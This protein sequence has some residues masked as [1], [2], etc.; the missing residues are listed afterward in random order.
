MSDQP[1][2]ALLPD[3]LRDSLPPEAGHEAAVLH[4]LMAAFTA[5]GYERVDPPL[6]EFE[7]S[8]L[9]GAG[10]GLNRHTFRLMDPVSQRMMGLRADMT[11]QV[12]RIATTRLQKSPRPLRLA[13]SGYVMRVR[14]NQLEPE[15]QFR[16][17]GVE[18]IGSADSSADAEVILLA[19]GALRAAGAENLSVDLNLPTV[20]NAICDVYGLPQDD[21]AALREALDGK[22]PAAV[23]AAGGAAAE[24]M[25]KLLS[26]AGPADQAVA[27]L[28]SLSARD[29]VSADYNRIKDVLSVLEMEAPD[30]TVTVDLV[31][32]RGFEYHTGLGFTFFANGVR[33]ELGRGGRYRAGEEREPATGFSLF[34]HHLMRAVGRPA[35]AKRVYLPFQT[36]A[37][38]AQKLRGEGWITVAGLTAVGDVKSEAARLGCGYFFNGDAPEAAGDKGETE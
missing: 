35:P 16:Q 11:P 31:E 1:H 22:D 38:A 23:A 14:G 19:Y 29:E 9:A 8:L 37:E 10:E 6:V 7:Q 28:E 33:G 20:V 27:A 30:L 15:R 2:K 32:N 3:G 5:H 13:Y 17:A 34:L 21:R 36:A 12:A 26:A 24:E 25:G 18:L 4:A